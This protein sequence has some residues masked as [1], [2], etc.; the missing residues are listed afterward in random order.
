MISLV[1]EILYCHLVEEENGIAGLKLFKSV[2]H[3]FMLHIVAHAGA[4][5]EEQFHSHQQQLVQMHK[6]LQQQ[7]LQQN[8]TAPELHTHLPVSIYT[9]KPHCHS[10]L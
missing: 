5:T 10:V 4:F 9:N 6:Q 3:Q 7:E 2:E 1:H 8:S